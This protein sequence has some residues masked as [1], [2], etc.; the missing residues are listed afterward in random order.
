MLTARPHRRHKYMVLY[1]RAR[2]YTTCLF[3]RTR[4]MSQS[5]LELCLVEMNSAL[6][7]H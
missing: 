4:G 1:F 7:V 2:E 3:V 6:L 5:R